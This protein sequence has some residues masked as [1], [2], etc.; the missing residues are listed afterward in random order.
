MARVPELPKFAKEASPADDHDCGLIKYRIL[1]ESLVK[2]CDRQTRTKTT[3]TGKCTSTVNQLD[4]SEPVALCAWRHM[5]GKD[6]HGARPLV[7]PDRRSTAL[8]R[9]TAGC[10]GCGNEADCRRRAW[11]ARYLNQEGRGIG[12][13][14]KSGVPLQDEGLDTSRRTKSSASRRPRATTASASRS[15]AT[16]TSGRCCSSVQS[17]KLVGIEGYGPRPAW[18]PSKCRRPT[19]RAAT[20]PPRKRSWGT[21]YSSCRTGIRD[22]RI[23]DFGI[24]EFTDGVA[25]N[26]QIPN[27]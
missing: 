15:C 9:A 13:A 17:T 19:A 25:A 8:A 22:F 16:G 4:K 1:T 26:P 2:R 21:S 23:W 3:A 6:V 10:A 20:S 18:L 12:L 7:M 11:R 14:N 24:C 27:P 5:S